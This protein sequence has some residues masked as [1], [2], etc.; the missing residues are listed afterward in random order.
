MPHFC[1]K[2]GACPGFSRE[3]CFIFVI[4]QTPEVKKENYRKKKLVSR[5]FI[6]NWP[7]WK[8]LLGRRFR[9]C[10]YRCVRLVP[11]RELCMVRQLSQLNF[12]VNFSFRLPYNILHYMYIEV[13]YIDLS[14]T[15]RC[16]MIKKETEEKLHQDA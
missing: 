15:Y 8:L 10:M 4:R 6:S 11:V 12:V 5:K 7:N 3:N 14:D 13:D 1:V 2:A 9:V 16:M